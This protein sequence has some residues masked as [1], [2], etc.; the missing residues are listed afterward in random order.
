MKAVVVMVDTAQSITQ[1]YGRPPTSSR[2]SELL[3][4][5][6][7]EAEHVVVNN[8]PVDRGH[9]PRTINHDVAQC[10]VVVKGEARNA[11]RSR[12]LPQSDSEEEA[13]TEPQPKS[14]W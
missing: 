1:W 12:N 3:R 10:R 7:T 5:D 2:Y 8:L 13:Q 9:L 11:P 4:P 6:L 14:Q